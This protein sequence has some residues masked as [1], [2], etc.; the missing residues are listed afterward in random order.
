MRPVRRL[1]EGAAI[2]LRRDLAGADGDGWAMGVGFEPK[3]LELGLGGPHHQ[4]DA[5]DKSAGGSAEPEEEIGNLVICDAIGTGG[6]DGGGRSAT[7]SRIGEP[8][9]RIG[10]APGASVVAVSTLGS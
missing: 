2:R 9:L 7:G 4:L 8:L 1:R 3:K 10:V 6:K 5:A